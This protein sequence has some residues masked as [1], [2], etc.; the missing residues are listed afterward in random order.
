SRVSRQRSVP[1]VSPF[2]GALARNAGWSSQRSSKSRNFAVTRTAQRIGKGAMRFPRLQMSGYDLT[3]MKRFQSEPGD[4]KFPFPAQPQSSERKVLLET[5]PL[6]YRHRRKDALH[7]VLP[8][9][10]QP[11]AREESQEGGISGQRQT[12]N[13]TEASTEASRASAT[14]KVRA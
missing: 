7:R 10:S 4:S 13:E 5:P 12:D 11:K 2:T 1:K 6:D 3:E 9:A 14:G 8:R